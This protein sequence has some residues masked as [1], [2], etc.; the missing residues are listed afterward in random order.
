[1]RNNAFFVLSVATQ[2][3]DAAYLNKA[4][5]EAKLDGLSDELDFLRQIFDAVMNL[6][7]SSILMICILSVTC[8]V[9][10]R[11]CP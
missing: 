11:P 5:L 1:M 3:T 7:F 4:E 8:Y 2:D 10:K 9:C 6:T